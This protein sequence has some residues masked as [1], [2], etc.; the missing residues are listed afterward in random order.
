[1]PTKWFK[2]AKVDAIPVQEGRRIH[3]KRQEFALFNLGGGVFKALDGHCPHKQGP[4]ADGIIAGD[5]VFCPL[6]NWKIS[7]ETGCALTQG[8]GSVKVYPTRVIKGEVYVAFQEGQLHPC[9]ETLMT[10][11]DKEED[12]MEIANQ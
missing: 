2:V 10:S 6:H 3:F 8:P 7:L 1:M 11:L 12:E 9:E 4:L 5:A